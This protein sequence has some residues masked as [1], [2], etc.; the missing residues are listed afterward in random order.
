MVLLRDKANVAAIRNDLTDFTYNYTKNS[1]NK[2]A[3]EKWTDENEING[4]IK[5][6]MEDNVSQKLTSI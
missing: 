3:D 4:I 1:V 5:Q 6:T 2:S